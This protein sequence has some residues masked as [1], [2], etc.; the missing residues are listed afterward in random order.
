MNVTQKIKFFY[1]KVFD[2]IC[3]N[4]GFDFFYNRGVDCYKKNDFHA[5]VKNFNI[6]LSKQDFK[7][8][9]YYNLA[10]VYQK[11]DDYDKA[12]KF[13]T[14]F[15]ELSPFDYDAMFNIALTY[16]LKG[17]YVTA[18]EKFKNLLE[19]KKES[20]SVMALT[21]C[22]IKSGQYEEIDNLAEEVLNYSKGG[23]KLY[24]AIARVLEKQSSDEK[25]QSFI[26]KAIK[27][28]DKIAE[29]E[30]ENEKIFLSISI[31]HAKKGLWDESIKFCQKALDL[32]P[33]S[34]DANNQM[35]L[36]YYC[37]RE[38]DKAIQYYSIAL[39]INSKSD[40]KIYANLA[41]AYETKGDYGK[42]IRLFNNL[43]NKFPKYPAKEEIRNHVRI[44]KTL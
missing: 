17:E 3:K 6:A 9:V 31:C 38:I 13:Y 32:E 11:I 12:I 21:N 18:I 39:K 23:E 19:V 41:Y 30:P 25:A 36:I 43:L 4:K 26:D 28:Y 5:A 10:L 7:P 34:Y 24:M 33:K 44:L 20:E 14:K 40:C 35:G 29:I 27:M 22:F 42:A 1:N 15:L 37:K 16:S 2:E 8:Q